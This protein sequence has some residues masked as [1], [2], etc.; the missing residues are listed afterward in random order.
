[1]DFFVPSSPYPLS[2]T[3][4]M[5]VCKPVL[6]SLWSPCTAED[7]LP[8][9]VGLTLHKSPSSVLK[10]SKQTPQT[11]ISLKSKEQL[12]VSPG[13]VLSDRSPPLL[14][15]G[16]CPSHLSF[17][18]CGPNTIFST[19]QSFLQQCG[20][21]LSAVQ[22][23]LWWEGHLPWR[24]GTLL[25]WPAWI[26]PIALEEAWE[27]KPCLNKGR[28]CLELFR[29][30]EHLLF[31]NLGMN[32]EWSPVCTVNHHKMVPAAAVGECDG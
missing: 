20:Q 11:T 3:A 13:W 7:G 23:Q 15:E 25:Q 31:R 26:S 32:R 9:V 27:A 29:E 22:Q 5:V 24:A 18:L 17:L 1:M 28:S 8:S 21:A 2:L 16:S 10:P 14:T 12:L 30:F 4:G 6:V 19:M